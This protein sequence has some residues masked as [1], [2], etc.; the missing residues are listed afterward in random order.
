[1][2]HF[3]QTDEN[4]RILV[5]TPNVEYA[6]AEMFAFAFPDDF[7]F[8]KQDDYRIVDGELVN[9]P[10]P[11]PVE[12]QIAALKAK[13]AET[14]YVVTKVAETM[15]TGIA[16]SDEEAERYSEIITQRR[17]WRAQIN[18]LEASLEGGE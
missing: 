1:M 6:G 9:D 12:N 16:L 13:L 8:S 11:E 7:D 4:G 18:D 3:V 17:E 15:V 14:D 5:T 2:M 10:L